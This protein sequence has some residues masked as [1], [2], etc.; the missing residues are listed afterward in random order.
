MPILGSLLKDKT[1]S[2]NVL[3]LGAILLGGIDPSYSD[4][5]KRGLCHVA[6][7]EPQPEAAEELRKK[8]GGNSTVIETVVGDGS[9]ATL[10]ICNYAAATSLFEPNIEMQYDYLGM[11]ETPLRVIE[12]LDVE[13]KKIDD[14]PEFEGTDF[15]KL[16]I[17]GAE[18]MALSSGTSVLHNAVVVQVEVEFL[19]LY[20][21]QP[22]F[23]EV[24]AFM[25]EQ[26]F[27]IHDF[28]N[29]RK[30]FTAPYKFAGPPQQLTWSDA[31]YINNRNGEGPNA[32][33][34]LLKAAL[35]LDHSYGSYDQA[36]N[37][38]EQRSRLVDDS[39]FQ[40]YDRALRRRSMLR[41]PAKFAR[42]WIKLS[43]HPR[44]FARALRQT[45]SKA[46]LK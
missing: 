30:T 10:H 18:I 26:D 1:P 6:L 5:W 27:Q 13:T 16:D 24:D 3:D 21:G 46:H 44:L 14:I 25:R 42:R 40:R 39:L 33:E 35:I 7:V 45:V 36:Y 41:R 11:F 43:R 38:L 19:E 22:L 37:M 23:S 9:P 34:N 15:I 28:V 12:K 31:V 8:V 17:Q 20:K 32:A 29:L 4:L 2:I